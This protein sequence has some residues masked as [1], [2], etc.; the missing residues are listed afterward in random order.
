MTRLADRE[1]VLRLA[2]LIED[3]TVGEQLAMLREAVDIDVQHNAQVVTNSLWRYQGGQWWRTGPLSRLVD[4]VRST[5]T[6]T[7]DLPVKAR[8]AHAHRVAIWESYP[9]LEDME[10]TG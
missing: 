7:T 4:E 8:D 6:L 2:C 5:T 10:A 1:A 3:R 9:V